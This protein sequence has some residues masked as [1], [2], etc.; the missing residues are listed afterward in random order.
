MDIY[1]KLAGLQLI[2]IIV[3]MVQKKNYALRAVPR[4]LLLLYPR[5]VKFKH[6]VTSLTHTVAEMPISCCLKSNAR[7]NYGIWYFCTSAIKNNLLGVCLFMKAVLI[8]TF[9]VF[10]VLVWY[11][12]D[13]QYRRQ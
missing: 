3:S 2:F 8:M 11:R 9:G 7:G 13:G 1:K 12:F 10:L 6:S 4:T 5:I